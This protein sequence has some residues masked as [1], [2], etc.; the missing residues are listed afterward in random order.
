MTMIILMICVWCDDKNLR[1]CV[2]ISLDGFSPPLHWVW[3]ALPGGE[4]GD[5]DRNDY[6]CDD[7]YGEYN[8]NM[9]MLEDDHDIDAQQ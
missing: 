1:E 8:H 2:R 4:R 7:G 9:M 6:H 3:L 5:G